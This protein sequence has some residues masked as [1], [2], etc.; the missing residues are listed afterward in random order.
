MDISREMVTFLRKQYPP[1]TR[2]RLDNMDDPFAPVPAGMTGTVEHIDDAGQFHMRWDNGRTLALIPGV[3]SF[4]VLPPKLSVMKLYMP[5]TADLYERN[6]WGDMPEEPELLSGRELIPYEDN[7]RSALVKYRMP[8]ELTR[9]LMNWYNKPDT[10]NNKVRSVTFGAELRGGQLW[11][12][13]ECQLWHELSA[14]EL[15]TLKEFITG[16]ASDGWGEGFEQ[17]E[18]AVGHGNELYVH[19]WQDHDWSIQ[20]E[21]ECFCPHLDKLP[22]MCFTLLPGTGQLICVKRGESGYY[23]SDWSTDDAHE[24]RLIADEQNRKLGVT[25]AQEEAMKIGSMCGWDVPG[26]DPDNCEDIVQRRGGMELG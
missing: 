19:L 4:T 16:Q 20:T 24:N 12:V 11:G 10:V 15:T 8:E 26:A 22:E 9:G 2:I 5:L 1:G 3:D 21:Q 18:I 13:A 17:R 6:E 23:P 25:P 14:A 7:I